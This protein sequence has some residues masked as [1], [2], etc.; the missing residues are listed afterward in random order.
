MGIWVVINKLIRIFWGVCASKPHVCCGIQFLFEKCA[1]TLFTQPFLAQK[2]NG[3][4]PV[5]IDYRTHSVGR[6][7]RFLTL[8]K[9]ECPTGHACTFLHSDV[10]SAATYLF[11]N[12]V[13][14]ERELRRFTH[15]AHEQNDVWLPKLYI[16]LPR[17]LSQMS[18]SRRIRLVALLLS[19]RYHASGMT[20]SFIIVNMSVLFSKDLVTLSIAIWN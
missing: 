13:H 20:Y 17:V 16:A 1:F 9:L 10:Q 11:R 14:F 2:I 15:A 6:M 3:E 12:R 5:R 7:S 19:I 4:I 8:L 18:T